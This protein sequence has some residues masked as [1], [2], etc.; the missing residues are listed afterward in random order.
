MR[1]E[2]GVGEVGLGAVKKLPGGRVELPASGGMFLG[3]VAGAL[4]DDLLVGL[5]W[6]LL[7]SLGSGFLLGL[8][9]VV[10]V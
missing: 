6:L 5:L 9:L 4:G 2:G 8:V 3:A 7:P 10:R 1:R